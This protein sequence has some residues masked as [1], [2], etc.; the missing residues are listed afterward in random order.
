MP[1]EA[2]THVPTPRRLMYTDGTGPLKKDT[3]RNKVGLFRR[4]NPYTFVNA[5]KLIDLKF[6]HKI[7]VA[8]NPPTLFT[9]YKPNLSDR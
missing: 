8:N 2:S 9:S 1:T 6:I 7:K 5:D 4:Q 3:W